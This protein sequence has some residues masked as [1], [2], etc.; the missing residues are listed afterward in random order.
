[1]DF[2]TWLMGYICGVVASVAVWWLLH[3]RHSHKG[4]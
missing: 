3:D 4:K 1:M 2:N